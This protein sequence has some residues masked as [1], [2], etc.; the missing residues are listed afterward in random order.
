TEPQP[1]PREEASDEDEPPPPGVPD[2]VWR[3]ML[4]RRG[5]GKFRQLLLV[6]Y[7]GRCAVT[8][9]DVI[10]ALEAAHIVSHATHADERIQNGLLLRADIHTLFDL[11]LLRIDPDSLQVVL[12][13]SIRE[14][15]YREWHGRTL[16]LPEAPENQPSRDRLALHW[17]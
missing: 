17:K 3:R 4:P 9:C 8:G 12:A 2:H 15:C 13:P 14:S 6:A 16:R 11:H 1:P 10:D 7:A 5:Q